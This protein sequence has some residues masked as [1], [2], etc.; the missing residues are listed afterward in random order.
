MIGA[1]DIGGTKI[2]VG[3]VGDD[4]RIF[5]Q[6]EFPTKD[7]TDANSCLN[8]LVLELHHTQARAKD[9]LQGIGIGCTGPVDPMKGTIEDV[10]FLPGWKGMNIVGVLN[11]EFGV[12][13]AL[14]ND[15]DAAALGEWAWGSGQGSSSFV[16]VTIGTGIGVGLVLDGK[17]YRGVNGSH[18]EIGH[19]VIDSSGP[20]CYCGVRGCW[21]VLA[22]GPALERWAQANHPQCAW[23]SAQ[24][25]C[26]E[27]EKGDSLAMAAVQH[28][29][30][31]LAIGLAN[32]V[33]MFSPERIALGG[34]LM[35]SYP[36]FEPVITKTIHSNCKLVP[37]DQVKVAPATLGADTGLLGAAYV[38]LHHF[39]SWPS[40]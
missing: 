28:T 14:E 4:G 9:E 27:A 25:I 13:T 5:G 24:Q 39:T 29:A 21:E 3:L 8:R 20:A 38:W 35:R 18:P 2:A 6:R 22:S 15:A 17:L 23:A 34:G 40:K 30:H 12:P 16:L 1:V 32:L 7:C 33:T 36:L 37:Y 31:Y 26:A 19:H 10:E 11:Q